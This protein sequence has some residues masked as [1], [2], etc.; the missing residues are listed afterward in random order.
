MLGDLAQLDSGYSRPS[1]V[2]TNYT[3]SRKNNVIC[4]AFEN[5]L[6]LHFYMGMQNIKTIEV[7]ALYSVFHRNC[8]GKPFICNVFY[9]HAM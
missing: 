6:R 1:L 2:T 4:G 9:P 7:V 5:T 8:A 3:I